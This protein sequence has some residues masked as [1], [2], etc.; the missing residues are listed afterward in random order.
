MRFTGDHAP[1]SAGAMRV[2]HANDTLTVVVANDVDVDAWIVR[3]HAAG[4]KILSVAPRY[5][6]L[7]DL[8]LREVASADAR[9]PS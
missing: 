4:A 6:T 8:F 1:L 7:E 5:E 3:A 2:L 9:E